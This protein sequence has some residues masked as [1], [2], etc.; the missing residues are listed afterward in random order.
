[1][2]PCYGILEER[3]YE[4]HNQ[5]T[6]LGLGDV[7]QD[8]LT[9][10]LMSLTGVN[11]TFSYSK[12]CLN[13]SEFETFLTPAHR[14]DDGLSECVDK[15]ISRLVL[16]AKSREVSASIKEAFKGKPIPNPE[17]LRWQMAWI[18]SDRLVD[19]MSRKWIDRHPE[20]DA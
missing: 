8:F 1:M 4:L 7:S 6:E 9:R 3:L 5:F 2:Q 18:E 11:Y 15:L 12:L 10:A 16:K 19:N 20:R 17:W 14:L 13:G